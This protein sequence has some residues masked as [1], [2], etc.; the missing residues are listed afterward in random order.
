MGC[1]IFLFMGLGLRDLGFGDAFDL[2]VRGVWDLA[3]WDACDLSLV[4]FVDLWL[5]LGG[6][7]LGVCLGGYRGLSIRV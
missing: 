1:L 4:S 3:F 5:R 7:G 6:L 2:G